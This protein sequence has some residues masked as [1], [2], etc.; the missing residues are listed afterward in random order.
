MAVS[1]KNGVRPFGLSPQIVLAIQIAAA[2][3]E[4]DGDE[5]VI[6][7]LADSRHSHTSLHY[8]GCAVDF[9]TH[10]IFD[11]EYKVERLKER[12]GGR[13]YDVLFEGDHI[14]LEYQPRQL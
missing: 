6:T 7:S 1:M 11:P 5:L 12:L 13:D 2:L 3:W 10:D 14:H 8:A 4:E 9:R